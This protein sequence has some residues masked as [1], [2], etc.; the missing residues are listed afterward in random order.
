[1]LRIKAEIPIHTQLLIYFNHLIDIS[2]IGL[3]VFPKISVL[4]HSLQKT[5][6][7]EEPEFTLEIVDKHLYYW[8]TTEADPNCV[9]Q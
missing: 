6:K 9:F 7:I 4:V 2:K 8:L 5:F 3:D 1:L